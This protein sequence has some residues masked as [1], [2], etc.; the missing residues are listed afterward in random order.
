LLSLSLSLKEE[1]EEEA[2]ALESKAENA[3]RP[4]E[5]IPFQASSW[6]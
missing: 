2:A 4:A 3:S 5:S 6:S 1:E